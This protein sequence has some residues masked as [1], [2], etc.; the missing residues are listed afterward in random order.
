VPVP[1]FLLFL[2]FRKA[3]EEIFSELDETKAKVPIFSDTRQSP[4][5]RWRGARGQTHHRVA[6]PSPWPR[7]QVV[8]PPGPP[9]DAA[10]LP[11]YSLRRENLKAPQSISTKHTASRHHHRHEIG[12]IQ[13]L[14]P[15]PCRRG[16]S[17]PEAFFI[18]MPAS[19]VMC[20]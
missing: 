20:E 9:P 15:A 4:K 3:T 11:I 10:L 14:F 12:R 6:R 17:P 1:Y 7:Y 18:T 5:L 16:E 2:C 13:K 19:E 8:W